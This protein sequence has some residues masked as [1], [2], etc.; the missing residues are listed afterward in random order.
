MVRRGF[1]MIG[2]SFTPCLDCL[3]GE[4]RKRE[5]VGGGKESGTTLV[6]LYGHREEQNFCLILC[7]CFF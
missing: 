6:Q 7:D 5:T 2:D 3:D 1:V 4:Y